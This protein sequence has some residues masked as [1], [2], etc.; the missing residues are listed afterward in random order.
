MFLLHLVQITMNSKL[1]QNTSQNLTSTPTSMKPSMLFMQV[2][3]RIPLTGNHWLLCRILVCAVAFLCYINS[4]WGVF[5]FDDS[6]AIIGNKD[7]DPVTPLAEVFADDFWGKKITD[8]TSHKSYRPLTVL[9]FRW[10][11]WLA[12]GR[13]PFGFHFTNVFLHAI[14]SLMFLEMCCCLLGDWPWRRRP[15]TKHVSPCTLFAALLFALHPIH[16]ESVS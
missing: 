3:L 4:S 15:G 14:A 2:P 9:T 10:N 11:Y 1:H 12:G 8:K 16:S 13:V 7:I 5:V 6:E